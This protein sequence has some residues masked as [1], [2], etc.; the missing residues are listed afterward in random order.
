M[1]RIDR[2]RDLLAACDEDQREAITAKDRAL[3]VLAGAGSGKTR[4]L[5]RRIAWRVLDGSALCAHVLT[6]TFTRK[7]AAELRGRLSLLG[8]PEPV[9]AGTFHSIALAELRRLAS[10]RREAPP[11]VLPSKARLLH[12]VLADEESFP[13]PLGQ[14]RARPTA[15]RHGTRR[16]RATDSSRAP[17]HELA[18]EIEWAKSRLLSPNDYAYAAHQAARE[19][20]WPY[21]DVALVY[22]AYEKA[23]RRRRVLDFEDLL[24]VLACELA[25]DSGFAAS[26]RWKFRH[27]FVDEYQDVNDSQ[28]RLLKLWTGDSVDL[29][30]VGDPDQAIYSWNGAN[31]EAII[32]FAADFPG[33]RVVRLRTN[34]RSTAEVLTIAGSVLGRPEV[35]V[36][37]GRAP[38]GPVPSV[39]RYSDSTS[40][41]AGVA[42]R[43]RLAHRPGRAWSQIAVLARTNAQLP[44]FREALET[45]FVPCRVAGGGAFARRTHVAAAIAD[46]A[47]AMSRAALASMASDLCDSPLQGRGV[48]S[49]PANFS[50]VK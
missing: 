4:V 29:S 10:E 21:E 47:R 12:A 7:A 18:A 33:A 50:P 17:V 32:H 34:Y 43:A 38:T 19:A 27:L 3:C 16:A 13:H 46:L 49:F 26:A 44:A 39:T 5:T 48:T 40:E 23:R 6:L 37:G 1:P 36:T 41:A 25:A 24:T 28:L 20:P 15:Q 8:L 42:E 9:T 35:T 22:E 31:P 11:V 2:D 14:A 30:V 45:L